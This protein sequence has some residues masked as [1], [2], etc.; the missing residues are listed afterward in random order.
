M[1]PPRWLVLALC[2]GVVSCGRQ[3]A[4]APSG[5]A[6]T[7]PSRVVLQRNVDL[8]TVE[9]RALLYRVETVGILEAEGQT[10][11]AAGVAGVVDEV[12]F[13]EG[14]E[15]SP[16]T[17]LV[18][19]DQ[20]K[21]Q[22]DEDLAIANVE[23]A[24]AM[25]D[26][27]SDQLERFERA[28]RGSSEEDRAKARFMVRSTEAE[29]RSASAALVRARHNLE[30][31]RVRAP[32][33][34]RIN[35]RNVTKGSY[36]EDKTVIATIA[37]LSHIRL[38][39]YVPETAAPTVRELFRDQ[40]RRLGAHRVA[41]P[42]GGIGGQ[43]LSVAVGGVLVARDYVPS[44]Y[45]PEFR[46]Q[47]A[48]DRAFLGR[49]FYMSTVANPETH[50]FEAKA[51][52]LGYVPHVVPPLVQHLKTLPREQARNLR[53]SI[54][55]GGALSGTPLA[56]AAGQLIPSNPEEAPTLFWPGMTAKIYFNLR[57]NPNALVIPEE[58]VRAS[59]RGFI[60]FVPVRQV[61]DDG[62]EEWIARARTLDLG[63]RAEGWVE[64]RQGL[65]PG[66][67]VVRRGAEALEDGTPIRFTA[68]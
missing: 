30:R 22:A 7:K 29:H 2:L 1:A 55:L 9:Q 68:P 12:L 4:P 42:L 67:R 36:L 34:G 52:V 11:I 57:S 27:A 25:W 15:V 50:M 41:L 61:R 40:E 3:G 56:A 60:A 28:G 43:P 48:P 31:S 33:A 49:I 16:G 26:L 44:G 5:G 37:D 54:F 19:I 32:Y 65:E 47:V 63:F 53:V 14:D 45:D 17:L 64:V 39:G 59:E 8:T 62:T 20:T 66:E 35:K 51:E 24:R 10:D 38:S 21:Y 58:A 18:K 23:R 46:L 13:R 6:D